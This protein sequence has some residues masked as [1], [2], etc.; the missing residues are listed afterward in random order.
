MFSHIRNITKGL[1][2]PALLVGQLVACN[3]I[4]GVE[5]IPA[6]TPSGESIAD[7]IGKDANYSVLKAGLTRAG[8]MATLGNKNSKLTLLA[9]DNDAFALGGINETVINALPLTQLVPLLQYHVIPQAL[10]TS[11][12]PATA[13]NLQMPTLLQPSSSPLFKMSTFPAKN[14]MGA[15]VNNIPLKATDRMAA[16][17]VIHTTYAPVMPPS[18]MMRGLIHGDPELTLFEAAVKRA[19]DG[20]TGLTLDS[21]LNYPYPNLTVFAPTNTAMGQ[22]LTAL[23]LPADPAV[24]AMLPV[25]TVQGLVAYHILGTN[26]VPVQRLFTVNFQSATYETMIGPAPYP[27][28]QIDMS[29][30]LAPTIKGAVNPSASHLVGANLH[31]V[32]GVLHKIDQVL[33]PQPF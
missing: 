3:K 25:Q 12:L 10:P 31:A 14:A 4:P 27:G 17:G 2:L 11:G 6:T 18:Q 26:R 7:I 20:Q 5:D 22:V 24:F 1:L 9:P 32:N 8:M 33:L 19:S 21:L 16:N 15:F 23:G 28:V 13:A 30:P 29:N